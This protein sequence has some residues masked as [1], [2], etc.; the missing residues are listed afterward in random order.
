MRA[1]CTASIALAIVISIT[2]CAPDLRGDMARAGVFSPRSLEAGNDALVT[3]GQALF[4]DPE[5]SGNRNTACASCHLPSLHAGDGRHLSI[6]QTG[7]RLPRQVVEPFNRSFATSFFW[8]A[9]LELVDGE[10]VGPVAFPDGIETLLEAQALLPLLDRAE[11]RGDPGDVADDGRANELAALDDARPDDIWAAVLARLLAIEGYRELFVTA[12]PRVALDAL[13]IVHVARAIAAFESRL[14]ELSDTP[15]DRFLGSVSQEPETEALDE[16]QRKGAELF[17]GDAGCARCHSGPLLTD[18]LTHA[19]G[20]PQIGPGRDGA[21]HDEGRFAITGDPTDRFAFRTPSLRNVG[22]TAPYMHDGA[23]ARLDD[24]VRHHLDPRASLLAYDP[25]LLPDDLRDQVHSELNDEIAAQI[26]PE[27]VPYRPLSDEEIWQIVWFL[28]ALTS[29]T[30]RGVGPE[31]GVP[32]S[33][34]SGLPV[35]SSLEP[36]PFTRF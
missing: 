7:A 11:M 15:F 17:F 27:V 4:F 3:L 22:V 18:G 33:V 5:L 2:G 20:V 34:P 36:E 23:F 32:T 24:A 8:D 29:D 6:G 14:W 13:S 12:Y 9:R 28:E 1:S 35:T 16:T 21:G 30:E 25:T 10:I 26:D 19:I 31:A